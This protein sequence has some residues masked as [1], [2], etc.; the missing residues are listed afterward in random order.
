MAC[1]AGFKERQ[2][3]KI[4]HM[5][6]LIAEIGWNHMGDMGLADNMVM[7]A[8]VAGA[9][10]AKFQIF[11][12]KNLKPGPWDKDGRRDIYE[13]AQLSVKQIQ[14]L[15]RTCDDARIKFMSSV[16]SVEDAKVLASVHV[17]DVK[18]PS[19]E[20]RNKNLIRF[21]NDNFSHVLM[22]T[23]TATKQEVSEAVSLVDNARLTLL[24]CVSCYPCAMENCNLPRI[25]H[26]QEEYPTADIGFSDH[27]EGTDASKMALEY[28]ISHIEK[29][30]TTNKGL[31]GRDN[32]FA[33]TPSEL[34]DLRYYMDEREKAMTSHGMDYQ[35]CEVEMREVYSGRWER[36]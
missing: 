5:T 22:S 28:G 18:I 3:R 20:I 8:K 27:T 16:F 15:I 6:E 14:K 29:H 11:S 34:R 32:K 4:L 2:W 13:K 1:R 7:A 25:Q 35:G 33:I 26:L 23:G 12:T 24:H 21:C 10:Y 36:K 31:P 30:F 19:S 9:D 17:R